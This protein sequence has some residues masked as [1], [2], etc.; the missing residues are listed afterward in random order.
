MKTL[1]HISKS[2]EHSCG[3]CESFKVRRC[4]K[5]DI[6]PSER[7]VCAEFS[8]AFSEIEQREQAF[9]IVKSDDDQMLVFGWLYV[10]KTADG[11][12]VVDHSGEVVTIETLEKASYE[13]VLKYRDAGDSHKKSEGEIISVGKLVE[14][15]VFTAEKIAAL[16]VPDGIIPCGIWAGFKIDEPETWEKIKSGE[17]KMFSFGGTA[18]PELLGG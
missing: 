7:E 9:E 5:F 16:G 18:I 6:A 10:S 2:T 11:K 15:I 12:Q 13:F 8:K 14:C 4:E 1:L 3:T 17:Y